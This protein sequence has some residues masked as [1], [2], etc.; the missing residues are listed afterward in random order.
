[1]IPVAQ[2]HPNKKGQA[3]ENVGMPLTDYFDAAISRGLTQAEM[4]EEL[5]VS[6]PTVSN[7]L[8]EYG[9]RTYTVY[10]REVA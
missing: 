9:Y 3:E 5:K 8:K 7:W 4:A 6:R 10:R 1:M 2:H